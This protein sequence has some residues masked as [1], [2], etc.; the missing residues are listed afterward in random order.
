VSDS[1]KSRR[2]RTRNAHASCLLLTVVAASTIADLRRAVMHAP[3]SCI[4]CG[5]QRRKGANDADC[6][7]QAQ[8][9]RQR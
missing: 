3:S 9:E 4:A 6:A 5:V 2:G 1:P 7:S 8:Q